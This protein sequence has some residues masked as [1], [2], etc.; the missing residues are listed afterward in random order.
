V[1]VEATAFDEMDL[2]VR[3]L[4]QAVAVR[5]SE[6]TARL[7]HIEIFDDGPPDTRSEL[8]T[9]AA[10][11][12]ADAGFHWLEVD[13]EVRVPDDLGVLDDA[14]HRRGVDLTTLA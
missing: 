9:G 5:A 11:A 7:E 12:A 3:A 6:D 13:A 4:G 2:P 14:D 8:V 10:H 1:W